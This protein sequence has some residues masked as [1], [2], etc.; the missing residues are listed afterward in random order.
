MMMARMSMVIRSLRLVLSTFNPSSLNTPHTLHFV[1]SPSCIGICRRTVRTPTRTSKIL[2]PIILQTESLSQ[3]CLP[4]PPYTIDKHR[5]N[6]PPR[7]HL[8]ILLVRS[9]MSVYASARGDLERSTNRPNLQDPS[10]AASDD[11]SGQEGQS[12]AAQ[13]MMSETPSDLAMP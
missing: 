3:R 7:R 4:R 11:S 2:M 9:L 8:K 12:P 1:S 6:H 13:V 10:E 5:A